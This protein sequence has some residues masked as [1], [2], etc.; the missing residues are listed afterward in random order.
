MSEFHFIRPQ[1]FFAIIPLLVIYGVMLRHRLQNKSW[2]NFCDPALLPHLF[3]SEQVKQH[4]RPLFILLLVGLLVITALAG[5]SWEKR[6]Q[7]VFKQQSALVLVLDLSR[8]MDATDIKPSRLTR[9]LHKVEDILNKRSEG[10]TALIV[11]A[12]NAFTVTPLTDDNA[13]ISSQV[14]SLSTD[15]MP[16]QG[17]HPELAIELAY[18]LFKQASYSR[19]HIILITDGVSEASLK[20][21]QNRQQNSYSLSVLAVGSEAGSPIPLS[22]GGF[23]KDSNGAIVIPKMEINLLRQLALTGSGSLQLLATDDSDLTRLLAPLDRNFTDNNQQSTELNTD[24][25]FEAGPWLLLAVIPFAALAFRRGYLF[26]L[27]IVLTPI[28]EPA[29]AFEWPQLWK[30]NNQQAQELLQQ[31]KATEAAEKFSDKKW[32][33]AAEYKA[34]LYEKALESYQQLNS[35][36]ANTLYNLANTQAKLGQLDQALENY[37]KVIEKQPDHSDA[38][39]NRELIEKLKQQ[40]QQADKSDQSEN[41]SDN[42]SDQN[43]Q[44]QSDNQ[45]DSQSENQ[46]PENSSEQSADNSQQ[47]NQQEQNKADAKDEQQQDTQSEKNNAAEQNNQQVAKEQPSQQADDKQAE[48]QPGLPRKELSKEQQQ[49]NEQWLRRIPDD[50]GGLL[51]RK[52]KYQSQQQPQRNSGDPQW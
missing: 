51:R 19:G 36:D 39:F 40:Q 27:L 25:W 18:K 21:I 34:G 20:K 9:A 33:A 46:Q 3:N 23:F 41:Q 16:S 32:R 15:I 10:Q 38:K 11:Y 17:S 49:A 13:T 29:Y 50:P 44:K 5:P 35:N 8:S 6:P 12:D 7:P 22:S 26:A 52:F 4:K 45:S 47:Q 1:W 42:K 30:N 2:Q 14:K 24:S 48:K 31:N 28:P 43:S 37:N